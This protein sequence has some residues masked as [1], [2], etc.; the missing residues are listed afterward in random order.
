MV[1]TAWVLISTALVFL[2]TPGLG[3]FYGG[4]VRTRHV[5]STIYQAFIAAGV[6]GLVWGGHRIQ[7]CLFRQYRQVDRR[8]EPCASAE[9]RP[10]A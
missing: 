6:A 5:V 8:P 7:P 4:M 3:F 10:G 2:M 9:R 1:D